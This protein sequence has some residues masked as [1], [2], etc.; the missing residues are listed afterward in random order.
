MG[1]GQSFLWGRG[2]ADAAGS[3]LPQLVG[4]ALGGGP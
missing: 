4:L 1:Q 3:Y 2:E